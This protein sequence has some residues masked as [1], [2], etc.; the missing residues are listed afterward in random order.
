[1]ARDFIIGDGALFFKGDWVRGGERGGGFV[2]QFLKQN[3]AQFRSS[4]TAEKNRARP[5]EAIR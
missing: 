1:M 4:R 3:A 2:D 5:R